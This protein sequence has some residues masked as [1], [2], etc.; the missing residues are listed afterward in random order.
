[1]GVGA[2]RLLLAIGVML[3]HVG[4]VRIMNADLSVELFF[5]ISGFYMALIL[6]RKYAGRTRLFYTNRL[7]RLAPAYGAVLIAQVI[8]IVVLD[9]GAFMSRSGFWAVMTGGDAGAIALLGTNL[10]V[11]GQETTSFFTLGAAHHAV[12]DPSAVLAGT[13]AWKLLLV[14]QA[15]SISLEIGFYL[16]APF[17]VRRPK[18]LYALLGASFLVHTVLALAGLPYDSWVRRFAPSTLHFF[19]LGMA[20]YGVGGRYRKRLEKLPSGSGYAILLGLV[21]VLF[22]VRNTSGNPRLLLHPLITLGTALIIPVLFYGVRTRYDSVVGDLSYPVYMFHVFV[23]G[24]LI[25]VAGLS[26]YAFVAASV[27][28]TLMLA[29][30]FNFGVERHVDAWRQR[31]LRPSDAVTAKGDDTQKVPV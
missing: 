7:F 15:W 12:W 24:L 30:I 18:T 21:V 25:K 9:A 26:G 22:A 23:I 14:P 16:V 17:L 20:A 28:G 2:L 27:T 10:T 3:G 13:P 4:H 1:M 5:V 6:E 11:I 31:R 29:A 19:L 8:A